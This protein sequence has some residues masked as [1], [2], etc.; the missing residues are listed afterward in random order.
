MLS[1]YAVRGDFIDT[2]AADVRF[3]HA[4]WTDWRSGQEARVYYGRLPIRLL[5]EAE[6]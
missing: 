2:V 4:V 3:V 1:N 5:L 6:R